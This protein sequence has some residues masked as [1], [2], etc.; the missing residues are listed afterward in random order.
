MYT[1][2]PSSLLL[3]K[4]SRNKVGVLEKASRTIS[5]KALHLH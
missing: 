3:N 1:Y 5:F 2:R 4:A